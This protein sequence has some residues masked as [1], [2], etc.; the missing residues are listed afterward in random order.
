VLSV[1][2]GEAA[3]FNNG[4][5]VVLLEERPAQNFVPVVSAAALHISQSVYWEAMRHFAE[6][7]TTACLP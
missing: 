5:I 2:K 7:Q 1:V 3:R 6:Q 4:D